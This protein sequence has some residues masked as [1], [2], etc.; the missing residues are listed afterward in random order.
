MESARSW[1]C[2]RG[3]AAAGCAGSGAAD[4]CGAAAESAEA[5]AAAGEA[6]AASS[7]FY[8]HGGKHAAGDP[9]AQL[10]TAV[11]MRMAC[12]LEDDLDT[13]FDNDSDQELLFSLLN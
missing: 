11:E 4:W 2:W 5:A 10:L 9:H 1:I 3:A 13:L 7:A 8:L 12:D 6:A